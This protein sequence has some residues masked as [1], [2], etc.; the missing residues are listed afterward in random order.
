MTKLLKNKNKKKAIREKFMVRE[1]VL[2]KKMGMIKKK[3][4]KRSSKKKK[5][6]LHS[7][8]R[9]TRKKKPKTHSFS[10]NLI[11]TGLWINL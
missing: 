8:L 7:Q 6:K 2:E 1:V 11:H 9:S 3:M 5:S 10:Q 4:M